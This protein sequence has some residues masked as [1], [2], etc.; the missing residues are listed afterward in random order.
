MK[1]KTLLRAMGLVKGPGRGATMT[2]PVLRAQSASSAKRPVGAAGED[3]E[4]EGRAWGWHLMG[5][6]FC[7]QEKWGRCAQP[8][9]RPL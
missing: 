6:V 8:L 3:P 4:A 7:P 9:G 5:E 1:I 2:E